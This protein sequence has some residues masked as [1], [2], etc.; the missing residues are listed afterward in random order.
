MSGRIQRRAFLLDLGRVTLGAVVLGAGAVACGSDDA[1]GSSA[2]DAGSSGSGSPSAT[3]TT[4]TSPATSTDTAASAGTSAGDGIAGSAWQRV[5]LGFVSAYVLVRDGE[6]VVVD[7][8]VEGSEGAIEATLRAAGAG[9]GQ[10]GQV[11][12]THRHPDHAGSITAVME[13]AANAIASTGAADVAAISAPRTI[14]PLADGDRVAGLRILAT[15][16]HTEGHISVLDESAGLLLAG[17]ALNGGDGGVVGPNPQFTPDMD[18]AL[19][20][21][22]ALTGL[23]FDAVVFGHGEPVTSGAA[24]QVAAI[25]AAS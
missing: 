17:D 4:A 5:D 13:A 7:T 24:D 10:V 3:G 2:S 14:M 21:V 22:R 11:I 18:T 6:A 20:S 25:A 8:G 9:W 23:T 1:A 12:L 19:A 16:G 15:P